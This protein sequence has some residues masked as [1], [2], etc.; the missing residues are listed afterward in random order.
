M[1]DKTEEEKSEVPANPQS[2]HSLLETPATIDTNTTNSIPEIENMEVHH[3]AHHDHGKK[4]WKS[5]FWEFFMLFLAVF[6]GFLAELQ[7]E[8]YIEN[9]REKKYVSHLMQDLSK[10]SMNLVQYLNDTKNRVERIDSLLQ[11]LIN[12]EAATRG[13]DL[14]YH[15]RRIV[16]A[17]NYFPSDASILQLKYSGNFRLIHDA[18]IVKQIGSYENQTRELIYVLEEWRDV[19]S[20]Y[21]ETLELLFDGMVFYKMLDP[22]NNLV[23]PTTNPQLLSNKWEDLNKLVIKL[24][25]MKGGANRNYYLAEKCLESCENLQKEIRTKYH[26]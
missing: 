17:P 15:A 22:Q 16:R 25:F 9:Q 18:N 3:H 6:C 11:I 19:N 14:Y 1:A 20:S 4:T 13:N 12:K 7:L 21:R 23:R 2:E 24:Q 26:L 10:D 8:H 5:Y